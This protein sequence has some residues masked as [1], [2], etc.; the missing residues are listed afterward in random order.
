[1]NILMDEQRDPVWVVSQ[2]KKLGEKGKGRGIF[3]TV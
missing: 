1:M 3:T 2:E